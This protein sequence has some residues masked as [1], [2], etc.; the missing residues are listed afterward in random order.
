ML[1]VK[2]IVEEAIEV[3]ETK[4][5]CIRYVNECIMWEYISYAD[6]CEGT[7]REQRF[8]EALRQL[9]EIFR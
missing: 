5:E 8:A 6:F 1:L 2:E 3:C 7:V 4:D 9:D